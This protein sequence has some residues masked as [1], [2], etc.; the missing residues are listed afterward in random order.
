MPTHRVLLNGREYIRQDNRWI[1]AR[2]YIEPELIIVRQ[3]D[4]HIRAEREAEDASITDTQD[5]LN[6]ATAAR[7][8]NQL[9]RAE[10]LIRR[11]LGLLIDDLSEF[12]AALA[13]LCSVLRKLNRS[14]QAVEETAAYT[15]HSYEP[16]LA[17]HAAALCDLGRWDEAKQVIQRAIGLPT[18]YQTEQVIKRI[19]RA[20]PD[21][22]GSE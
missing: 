7:D 11:A 8:N 19:K 22:Y 12:L 10:K 17:S 4:A 1:D 18:S 5:L 21:L 13:I 15:H 14:G 20:R 2:T 9:P 3:L 16:L 6:A